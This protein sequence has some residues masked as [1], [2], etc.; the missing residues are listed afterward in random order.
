MSSNHDKLFESYLQIAYRSKNP[1]QTLVNNEY[2]TITKKFIVSKLLDKLVVPD[3]CN[4][5]SY[6]R[7][8]QFKVVKRIT[9]FMEASHSDQEPIFFKSMFVYFVTSMVTLTSE[10]VVFPYI[11]PNVP[12]EYVWFNV[13]ANG[14]QI[15][16]V[17]NT[18]EDDNLP[19]KVKFN[20]TA[21]LSFDL[22]DGM[23][24]KTSRGDFLHIDGSSLEITQ[25][26]TAF[27]CVVIL[28]KNNGFHRVYYN[29]KKLET[30]YKCAFF[31]LK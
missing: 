10:T 3:G 1:S 11:K 22:S 23:Q 4:V 20:R 7:H 14:K 19:F 25:A 8:P 2:A 9:D 15:S 21:T 24:M 18:I 30:V 31:N 26:T 6:E 27:N 17:T 12:C 5:K 29:N 16:L 28:T 13:S